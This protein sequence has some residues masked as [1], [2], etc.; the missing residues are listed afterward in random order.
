MSSYYMNRIPGVVRI[1]TKIFS[2]L[3]FVPSRENTWVEYHGWPNWKQKYPTCT[4]HENSLSPLTPERIEGFK[5]GHGWTSSIRKS[6][7]DLKFKDT[8]VVLV[9]WS[10]NCILLYWTHTVRSLKST[11]YKW[12]KWSRS[13]KPHQVEVEPPTF[14]RRVILKLRRGQGHQLKN[15]NLLDQDFNYHEV[16][17]TWMENIDGGLMEVHC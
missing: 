15:N 7:K 6:S 14:S 3:S 1:S 10:W 8:G 2:G 11:G 9:A 4:S 12:G 17:R 16:C 13:Q 5:R